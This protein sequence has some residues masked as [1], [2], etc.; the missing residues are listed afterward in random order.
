M[1]LV[2]NNIPNVN[3][4][5]VNKRKNFNCVN[6]GSYGHIYKTCNHPI[7]S[8]GVICYRIEKNKLGEKIPLYLMVQRKDSLSY[9]EF[10]R[11]KYNLENKQYLLKLFENMT[12]DEH[13]KIS[14]SSFDV[15]W[16]E[17]WCKTNEE[18]SKNYN[19]EFLDSKDKFNKLKKGYYIKSN[20][21]TFIDFNYLINNINN[22]YYETEWGF[23]KGR[24]NIN[25]ND[26]T[27]AL[28]EFKEETGL[29]IKYL[30]IFNNIKPFEEI[31]SGTNKKRYKHVYYI[32][33]YSK[34]NTLNSWIP[35]CKEI[36]NVRWFNYDEAQ[37]H[38]R[39]LNI[40]RKELLRRINQL[41]LKSN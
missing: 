1:E 16:Q 25:E 14:K 10:I 33:N 22:K 4:F 8:Y 15:L 35:L 24:R 21:I 32:A 12:I 7:I 26:M 20:I 31:F 23:P 13:H 19:R 37:E 28:R 27:C 6:C 39:N 2:V 34:N 30:N 9:V 38:I 3:N 11:G 29:N 41:I 36:K 17:M 18:K 5:Y 40:E